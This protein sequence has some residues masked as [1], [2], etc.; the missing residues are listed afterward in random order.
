MT[1]PASSV[2]AVAHSMF[3]M[4]ARTF[5]VAC[6]S[7]EFFYFPQVQLPEPQWSTWDCFSSE[8]VTEITQCLS[9]WEHELELCDV[10]NNSYLW[11]GLFNR[12]AYWRS[13]LSQATSEVSSLER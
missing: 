5:P 13:A 9:A 6:A 12:C 11:Y 8:T 7:D 10:E 4:L 2:E 3:E 1:N